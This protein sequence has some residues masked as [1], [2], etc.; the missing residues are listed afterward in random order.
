MHVDAGGKKVSVGTGSMN[1]R[2]EQK[3]APLD[4]VLGQEG[5]GVFRVLPGVLAFAFQDEIAL[6][7]A[8][9]HQL[10]GHEIGLGDGAGAAGATAGQDNNATRPGCG[11]LGI[12]L[13]RT[14]KAAASPDGEGRGT[15]ARNISKACADHDDR[16]RGRP[17][18]CGGRCER[19]RLDPLEQPVGQGTAARKKQERDR[20]ACNAPTYPAVAHVEGN[21]GNQREQEKESERH[22]YS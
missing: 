6:R 16:R 4:G 8:Q 9:T 15:V 20:D 19:C 12:E 3:W 17:V 7:N 11:A 18:Y 2:R 13:G 14:K 5:C 1:G 22:R 10:L 21:G